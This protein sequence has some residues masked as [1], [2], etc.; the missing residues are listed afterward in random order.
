MR[1]C[2][3][4]ISKNV[5]ISVILGIMLQRFTIGKIICATNNRILII[6]EI[7]KKKIFKEMY[8]EKKHWR[9]KR[10]T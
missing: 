7:C 5:E 2:G 8:E 6:A 1:K 9:K 3:W 10:E 4:R